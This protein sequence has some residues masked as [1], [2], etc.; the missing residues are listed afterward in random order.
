MERVRASVSLA[1]AVSFLLLLLGPAKADPLRAHGTLG[2]AHAIG[3]PQVREFGFGVAGSASLEV[4]ITRALGVEGKLSGLVLAKGEPPRDPSIAPQGTGTTGLGTVGVR[5]RPFTPIAGP[6][7]SIGLGVAQTGDRTRLGLDGALG[8]DFRVV[9]ASRIDVGPYVGLVDVVQDDSALRPN[10]AYVLSLGVHV[11]LGVPE[12][13]AAPPSDRDHD[14]IVDPLDACPDEAG[15][16]TNDPKTNGCP[17]KKDRD[18]DGVYDDE[19]ACPDVAGVRTSDPKTNG[20]PPD[21]DHDGVPDA[22]DACPDV[23]GVRTDDPKTNGCPPD[24]DKDGITDAEDACPDEPG[25]KTNDPKTNGCPSKEEIRIVDERIMF[26]EVILFDL[27][28]PRVRHASWGIIEKLAD[29]I[30]KNPDVLEVSIEGHADATGTE[31]HNLYLSRE[32]A[33]SVRAL[34]IKFGVDGN[35]LKAEAFGRSRLKVETNKAEAQNRRVEFWVTRRRPA[36][37]VK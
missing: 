11:G 20:C 7:A 32:R 9:R 33:Q 15:V 23:P 12:P 5:A 18:G 29:F 22:V 31:Q 30:N 26:D 14:G 37:G 25:V 27:D 19:D 36:E 21:R 4:P 13:K 8:W 6:W 10:D 24:R 3:E 17:P 28:S 16:P 2:V 1:S 34:L 35:R